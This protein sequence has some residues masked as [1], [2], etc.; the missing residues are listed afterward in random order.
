MNTTFKTLFICLVLLSAASSSYALAPGVCDGNY[1]SASYWRT[2]NNFFA[3]M[4][5][6]PINWPNS[7]NTAGKTCSLST[8]PAD[9]PD[10]WCDSHAH[11]YTT[12]GLPALFNGHFA[13]GAPWRIRRSC[14]LV[15]QSLWDANKTVI[16]NDNRVIPFLYMNGPSEMTAS[17]VQSLYN[18]GIKGIKL[19]NRGMLVNQGN[20]ICFLENST[21]QAFWSKCAELGLPII[22]H[23]ITG[24]YQTEI[25]NDPLPFT[26][27]DL[28]DALGRILDAHPTLKFISAHQN[29]LS[30]R[31]LDSLMTKY[32]NFYTDGSV[33][34]R[35]GIWYHL[36][37]VWRDSLRQYYIKHQNQF[38]FGTDIEVLNNSG[39]VNTSREYMHFL[40]ELRLPMDVFNKVSHK[41]F[42]T[43]CGV[44]SYPSSVNGQQYADKLFRKD[45]NIYTTSLSENT[46]M[47]GF[48]LNNAGDC[49]VRVT[50]ISGRTIWNHTV[51]NAQSGYNS[52]TWHYGSKTEVRSGICFVTLEQNGQQSSYRFAIIR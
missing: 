15:S 33:H 8:V 11:L 10:Y 29:L 47:F 12:S 18:D 27:Q 17:N 6:Q 52:L 14:I 3:D 43:L 19:H 38:M 28:D 48:Q 51:K 23:W 24:L 50:D 39:F 13:Y 32:P 41:N 35:L 16:K 4:W 1:D 31:R 30:E 9:T 26:Y 49:H 37:C 45:V 44:A 46:A 5:Y 40:T 25:G 22:H 21:S 42:E 7:V 2:N 34:G 20:S 36:T